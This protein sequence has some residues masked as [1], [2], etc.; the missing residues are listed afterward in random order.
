MKIRIAGLV[1]ESVVDGP[2]IR[3][4]VFV[5]GCPHGCPGCHNP[6][7]HNFSGGELKEEVE[8]VESF[9]LHRLVSGITISGGEPFCQAQA[10]A[11]LAKQ[12]K[13]LGKS[14]LVYSGFTFEQLTEMAE[15]REDVAKLLRSTDILVD[16][17]YVNEQR[18]L[19]LAFRGSTNQR[20][21]DI[22]R[23]LRSGQ[24]TELEID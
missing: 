11:C 14:V 20:I 7:T 13:D 12:V 9:R 3:F 17:P 24:V 23:S 6:E 15:T 8:I 2:G 16:G 4:V 19:N 5:Q 18:N 21:I 10:C 1:P 22:P